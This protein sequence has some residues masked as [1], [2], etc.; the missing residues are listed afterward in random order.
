VYRRFPRAAVALGR[1]RWDSTE[2]AYP[3]DP[4]D[5]LRVRLA[6]ERRTRDVTAAG[7]E[8]SYGTSA[9]DLFVEIEQAAAITRNRAQP[10]PK[11]LQS[12]RD[13]I[14]HWSYQRAITLE[15]LIASVE[16]AREYVDVLVKLATS[17][18][19]GDS[20]RALV[21]LEEITELSRYTK[22]PLAIT[23]KLPK[24]LP[25]HPDEL[26]TA[27]RLG[28]RI[29]ARGPRFEL[30]RSISDLVARVPN[31]HARLAI[32]EAELLAL[33]F[34]DRARRLFEYA[35]QC[36]TNLGDEA[37]A[38]VAQLGVIECSRTRGQITTV[39]TPRAEALRDFAARL[40]N[41]AESFPTLQRTKRRKAPLIRRVR[42]RASRFGEIAMIV[43]GLGLIA[44][45]VLL[46]W[47]VAHNQVVPWLNDV[48]GVPRGTLT[49]GVVFG[50]AMA[51][52]ALLSKIIGGVGFLSDV[53][54]R[55][56]A[57]PFRAA[58][59]ISA[60]ASSVRVALE[61]RDARLSWSAPQPHAGQLP[62]VTTTAEDRTRIARLWDDI[63][64]VDDDVVLIRAD[65]PRSLA[66]PAW[67]TSLL[68]DT[69][70]AIVWR[71][72]PRGG[73]PGITS[74]VVADVEPTVSSAWG[75]ADGIA[76]FIGR[77]RRRVGAIELDRLAPRGIRRVDHLDVI[78][79]LTPQDADQAS[80]ATR[81]ELG[82]LRELAASLIE[83]G[84][85]SV[86]VLP[87]IAADEVLPL[88]ARL[89][90]AY[91]KKGERSLLRLARAARAAR[92]TIAEIDH[93]DH[94]VVAREISLFVA[95]D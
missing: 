54:R 42:A 65:I 24:Q 52:F 76:H 11:G 43:A 84:A 88:A 18:N 12:A 50:V 71:A 36:L 16:S 39:F 30:P 61:H 69:A 51:G 26:E 4:I 90:T 10:M 81:T 93:S 70:K 68:G 31:L 78:L 46:I 82:L 74:S 56:F 33:R 29:G 17:D 34:P 1:I 91:G 64:S 86:L 5:S 57:G 23:P 15:E 22:S 32:E 79:Q 37:N 59:T 85:R 73:T 38:E 63:A 49:D 58:L 3:L 94:R 67:E 35:A 14:K 80:A 6:R 40:G 62:A 2:M 45:V 60:E 66:A 8:Q 87:A 53:A 21:T 55:L 44:V 9:G 77:P 27:I 13:V 92:N 95:V 83:R 41:P 47:R 48:L 72:V 75:N 28:L 89:S 25:Q 7:S 19:P 20:A